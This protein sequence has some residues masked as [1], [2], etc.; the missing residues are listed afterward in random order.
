MSEPVFVIQNQ[1]GYYLTRQ[2][3][4]NDGHDAAALFKTPYRDI[5]LN[6]LIELNAKDIELR[7]NIVSV[8]LNEKGVPIVAP[9]DAVS[10][11]QAADCAIADTGL[12]DVTQEEDAAIG[13]TAGDGLAGHVEPTLAIAEE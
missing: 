11:L 13:S 6:T 12:E 1:H 4:W 2:N 10:A 3:E 7:G 9:T 8:A 5:A